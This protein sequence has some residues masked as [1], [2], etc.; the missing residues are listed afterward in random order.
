MSWFVGFV[1]WQ[2]DG[3]DLGQNWPRRSF[4]GGARKYTTVMVW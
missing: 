1:T 3:E 4:F 2:S